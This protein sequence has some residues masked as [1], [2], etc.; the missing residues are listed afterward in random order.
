VKPNIE[1]YIRNHIKSILNEIHDYE[2]KDIDDFDDTY[3]GYVYFHS[4]NPIELSDI[5]ERNEIETD[6]VNRA[7]ASGTDSEYV[8]R[9]KTK[10]PLYKKLELSD[11]IKNN[12]PFDTDS[13]IEKLNPED[14]SGYFNYNR[15]TQEP[16]SRIKTKD[17][18][19]FKLIGGFRK[20]DK[21]YPE[22]VTDTDELSD[23][24]DRFLSS[25]IGGDIIHK[26]LTIDIW[27]E[28]TP[29]RPTELVK[30]YKGI[31]EVQIR[32]ASKIQ[33]PYKVGQIIEVSFSHLTSWSTNPLVARRFIDE[34]P[35]SPAFVVEMIAKPE[36]VVV[37][38]QKLPKEY[39]HSNQREMILN[40]GIYKFKIVW[41]AK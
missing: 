13:K 14:F 10:K 3:S 21:H 36:N 34:Y 8:Y 7:D 31:E 19:S 41:A 24:T 37:D 6:L 22:R 25:Y 18:T 2:K 16:I 20:Y 38:V 33:P 26:P 4:Q 1:K 15:Y 35:S 12:D 9:I 5:Q 11:Y 28:L 23:A 27:E 32:Y 39:Y 29:F 17:I 30:I 40:K